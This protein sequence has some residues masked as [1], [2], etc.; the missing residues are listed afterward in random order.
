MRIDG[1]LFFGSVAY[2]RER[3]GRLE[4]ERPQ[5]KHLA[6]VAQG[7]AFADIAGA[8]VLAAEAER[9]R[10]DGGGLY[11]INAKQALWD[12]LEECHAIDRID[13]RH[14]FQTKSNALRAIY[15]RLDRSICDKC[16]ARIFLEC[17]QPARGG[18]P[19]AQPAKRSATSVPQLDE[20]ALEPAVDMPGG[21]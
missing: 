20:A 13:P 3:F 18:E 12:S 19:P 8:D 21:G 14:F 10:A 6:I 2:I 7:I 1:S 17:A 4:Q 5:Q 16:E 9:R 11:V 15:Q